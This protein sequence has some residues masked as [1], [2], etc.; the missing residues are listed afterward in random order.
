MEKKMVHGL[1]IHFT[2]TTHIDHNDV[3]LLEV[4]HGKDLP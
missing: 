1:R 3:L 2:H 4:V